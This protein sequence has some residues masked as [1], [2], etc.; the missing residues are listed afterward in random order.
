MEDDKKDMIIHF[1]DRSHRR[2]PLPVCGKNQINTVSSFDVK[3][4]T[5]K[6]CSRSIKSFYEQKEV[7]R[8]FDKEK[9]RIAHDKDM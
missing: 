4:V 7:N 1:K 6:M 3:N 5:C 9:K 2:F 8:I